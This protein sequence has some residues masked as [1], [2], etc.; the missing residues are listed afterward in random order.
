MADQRRK[1]DATGSELFAAWID[2][3]TPKY[4]D[5][6]E[7]L[8]QQG[9]YKTALTALGMIGRAAS[10]DKWQERKTHALDEA[11]EAKL[12]EA[13]TIDAD[14][15]IRS[16]RILNDRM[17]YATREHADA[18]V[19]MRESVRKPAP[20]TATTLNV[21]IS[22]RE[23][24]EAIAAHLGVPVDDVLAEAEAIAAGAWDSWSPPQ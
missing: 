5:F 2:A 15:F 21:T 23:K 6:A 17:K 11:A 4:R 16:S 13:A 14:T 12:K 8:A 9:R 19:K 3:G 24:A 10:R 20:K 7:H 22:I 1:P 18:I